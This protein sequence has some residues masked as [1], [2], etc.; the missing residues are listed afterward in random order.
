MP[1][2]L[3][4]SP[5]KSTGIKQNLGVI[6]LY[7]ITFYDVTVYMTWR[8]CWIVQFYCKSAHN[9]NFPTRES[10]GSSQQG[11]LHESW[12]NMMRSC[13]WDVFFRISPVLKL[14]VQQIWSEWPTA[15]NYLDT[16][17]NGS[18][19]VKRNSCYL[20]RTG[21]L[22]LTTQSCSLHVWTFTACRALTPQTS[23]QLF[24]DSKVMTP[25]GGMRLVICLKC[26]SCVEQTSFSEIK[27]SRCHSRDDQFIVHMNN[28]VLSCSDLTERWHCKMLIDCVRCFFFIVWALGL[29]GLV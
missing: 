8:S 25:A 1:F 22:I 3:F 9:I 4:L 18:S 29:G 10:K 27:L 21:T 2:F 19:L 24:N 7:S 12:S 23:K 11:K 16:L 13:C 5:C 20:E 14:S 17:S 15:L 28:I 26:L 6:N